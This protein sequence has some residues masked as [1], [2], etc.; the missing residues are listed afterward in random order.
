MRRW[1]WRL[2]KVFG[3]LLL[4]LMI[5]LP[6][7]GIWTARRA[8]PRIDGQIAARGLAAPVKVIRDRL[9]I[10]HLYARDEA[11][12]FFAQGYAHAQDRLWQ[13]QLHRMIVEGTLAATIGR[14]GLQPDRYARTLG[15]RRAAARAFSTLDP[16]T[17][18]LLRA[19]SDGVNAAIA[20]ARDRLPIEMALLQIR[21]APWSPVDSLCAINL[22]S[23]YLSENLEREL[24]RIRFLHTPGGHGAVASQRLL[25]AY[26]ADGPV[27]VPGPAA[28]QSAM[29]RA[30]APASARAGLDDQLLRL[31]FGGNSQGWGSNAW[32]IA[33]SHTRSGRPLL[34]NDTHLGLA[35]PSMWYENE[36]HGGRFDVAGF[37]IP[38]IP[39]VVIGHNGRIAWGI[40]NL[41]TDTQ[42]LFAETLDDA[43]HPRRYR[44]Q[45]GWRELA[46]V[47]ETI[48][49]RGGKPETLAVRFTGHG[50]LVNAAFGE[51]LAGQPPLALAW[52][53]LS[54][55]NVA[56]ALLRLDL[57]GDWRQFREALRHW[58]APSLGFVY[59][60]TGGNIGFQATGLHPLRA[61]GHDGTVPVSGEGGSEWRGYIP[62]DELPRSLNPPSGFIVSANNKVA[63]D[64]Y[65]YLLTRDWADPSRAHRIV[66]LLGARPALDREDFKRIQADTYCL[67]AAAMRPTL[68]GVKPGN[69][70]ERRALAEVERWDLRYEPDRIGASIFHVWQWFVLQEML[71][72]ELGDKLLRDYRHFP[73]Q[74]RFIT[75]DL[76]A[77]STNPWFE[78]PRTLH[79]K[80]REELLHRSLADALAWLV[81]HHGKDPARWTWGRLHPAPF[82][83]LPF[84]QTGLAPL[85]WIFNPKPVP[86][87]GG[88]FTVNAAT[89]SSSRPFLV[90]A[91]VSQRFIADL[92][93]LGQSLAVN[94][95]GQSGLL[96]HR[97]YGDQIAAW[98]AV[99]YHRIAF[100]RRGLQTPSEGVLTLVP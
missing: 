81:E 33:G 22:M 6:T 32:V 28:A 47:V 43:K 79:V 64:D 59:A 26:P 7:A 35:T 21:P 1:L 9:G 91:G 41:F 42:D 29:R 16:E 5:G 12:L 80:T 36:L 30:A 95:T 66:D 63:G 90:M 13:M 67:E 74:Q 70:L 2:L 23:L 10:P 75:Q 96:L 48:A 50:P 46:T 37:S 54:G 53:A 25:P 87:A 4:A 45:G 99:G 20:A 76:L 49:V 83:H 44:F 100:D 94:S 78:H 56:P 3:V 82:G 51:D 40:T 98:R 89:P 72:D 15:L 31:W 57:A 85:D 84:G 24:M 71:G 60:D 38:G 62:F 11:D 97:H 73:L 52:T 65:P 77:W 14:I 61:P 18:G 17:R 69:D 68:L 92:A 86:A 34:A 58:D 88:P 55:A 8:W 93:D 39:G 27:I 19:Y